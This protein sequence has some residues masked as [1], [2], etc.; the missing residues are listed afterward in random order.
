MSC[1]AA[2]SQPVSDEEN[3][4]VLF[5][6][7][8]SDVDEDDSS[9]EEPIAVPVENIQVVLAADPLPP[10]SPRSKLPPATHIRA[11]SFMNPMNPGIPL[12]V[13]ILSTQ[14]SIA[15]LGDIA[16]VL[17]PLFANYDGPGGERARTFLHS[18]VAE[19]RATASYK[20]PTHASVKLA[21]FVGFIDLCCAFTPAPTEEICDIVVSTA[22]AFMDNI[23]LLCARDV[24]TPLKKY[25]SSTSQGTVNDQITAARIVFD[26]KYNTRLLL[27]DDRVPLEW[28]LQ[29]SPIFNNESANMFDILHAYAENRDTVFY[30]YAQYVRAELAAA[31]NHRFVYVAHV[32]LRYFI[33]AV[34]V[35]SRL[36]P[37]NWNHAIKNTVDGDQIF[38]AEALKNKIVT[39]LHTNFVDLCTYM[40]SEAHGFEGKFV[41]DFRRFSDYENNREKMALASS[42]TPAETLQPTKSFRPTMSIPVDDTAQQASG[43]LML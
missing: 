32:F 5:H 12:A 35:V 9:H 25:T 37:Y 19:V 34:T 31:F 22:S 43:C 27:N 2:S 17:P 16:R 4:V 30:A 21:L 42:S 6:N 8:I 41:V 24:Y 7:G 10:P 23:R 11:T 29:D 20:Y 38:A 18:I 33:F 28:I 13:T 15:R 39:I 14:E 1:V 26:E 40:G 36:I 3:S